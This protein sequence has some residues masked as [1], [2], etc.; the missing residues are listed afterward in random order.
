MDI[1]IVSMKKS[2]SKIL[3]ITLMLVIC[4]Q[5]TTE[6]K[7]NNP[8]EGEV[9]SPVADPKVNVSED[10]I[11]SKDPYHEYNPLNPVK[12]G[13]NIDEY[14]SIDNFTI[15]LNTIESR[16]KYFSP[17][18]TSIKANAESMYWMSY[19]ARGGND[20]LLYDYKNYTKEIDD[21][22]QTYKGDMNDALV[23]RSLLKKDDPNYESKYE[24]LTQKIEA[25]KYMYNA[26]TSSYRVANKTI[27]A[28]K[29]A[30]GLSRALYNIGTID[31]NNQVAF[32]RRAVTKGIKS[33]VM[34][35]LQLST[36]A[37]ILEKQS[38]LYYDM[39]MLKLKNQSLGLATAVD[40]KDSINTYENAKTNYKKTSTTLRNVKEQLAINLGY[41]LS[42]ID[43]LEF[44]EPEVDMNYILNI[45]F[46]DD[47]VRAYTSNSAYT[48]ITLS[49]KDRKYPQS[50]G[51]ELLHKRQ[52]YTSNKVMNEFESIYSN[53]QSK[54]LAYEGSLYLSEIVMINRDANLRKYQNNLISE[55]EYKGLEI[56]NLANVL[57]VKTAKYDL[58]NATNDYYYGALGHI[59][60]S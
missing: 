14:N 18:Y 23:E 54:M 29:T 20:V 16:I 55:L 2:L 57:Q 13:I 44:V 58:I 21:L 17:A 40:V 56:Q 39:Y 52:E 15:D 35:Y 53:L 25:Y 27:T 37:E 43:K 9:E 10:I 41:K 31:N 33:L 4:M 28:T 12:P 22:R 36:Y 59:T 47:K 3:S 48:S 19:Y 24:E 8:Y 46:E 50:T 51:E 5:I 34:T 60:I 42:D 45:N 11:I 32:A 30:L 7:R 38:K 1:V 6:A 49:D 26:A